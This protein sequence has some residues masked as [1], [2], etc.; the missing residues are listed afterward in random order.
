VWL[1]PPDP[2]VRPH[3]YA[4]QR[5]GVTV[6]Y[7]GA[8]IDPTGHYPACSAVEIAARWHEPFAGLEGVFTASASC[9]EESTGGGAVAWTRHTG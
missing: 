7:D 1:H 2:L 6:L 5:G 9:R 8:P 4:D 3:E